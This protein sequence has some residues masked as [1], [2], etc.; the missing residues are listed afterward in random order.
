MAYQILGY[1]EK[2]A[3]MHFC[4][5]IYVSDVVKPTTSKVFEGGIRSYKLWPKKR[6]T[7]TDS[8]NQ[9]QKEVMYCSCIFKSRQPMN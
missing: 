8:Q 6:R 4:Y 7:R 3:C 9:E 5:S 1:S 2:S